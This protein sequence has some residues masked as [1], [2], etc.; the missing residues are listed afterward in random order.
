MEEAHGTNHMID[1]IIDRAIQSLRNN[2]VEINRKHWLED[3]ANTEKAG[4]V[5][6]CKAIIKHVI[7]IGIDEEER[8][9]AWIEDAENFIAQNAIECARAIY[10]KLIETYPT[11]EGVY[12]Q[13]AYFEKEYGTSDS[14]IDLLE[15]AVQKC[16]T[17]GLYLR[18]AKGRFLKKRKVS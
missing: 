18:L 16:P 5:L 10:D 14:L 2:G 9:G 1:K 17:E 11:K 7:G 3:A 6:T 4:S 8:E 13:A 15:R 12:L